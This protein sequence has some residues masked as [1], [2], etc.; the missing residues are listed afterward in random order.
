MIKNFV[1]FPV[2]LSVLLLVLD[3]TIDFLCGYG[4]FGLS[5]GLSGLLCVLLFD[6]LFRALFSIIYRVAVVLSSWSSALSCSSV[7]MLTHCSRPGVREACSQFYVQKVWCLVF[8]SSFLFAFCVFEC[9]QTFFFFEFFFL[10]KTM[11]SKFE[12]QT[13]IRLPWWLNK[14]WLP[15]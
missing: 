12:P 11:C 13:D 4:V 10:F 15:Y 5:L 7:S 2:L 1:T 6:I 3:Y 9:W 8:W 14:V